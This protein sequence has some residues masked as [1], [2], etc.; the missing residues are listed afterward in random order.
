MPLFA[1][2]ATPSFDLACISPPG[3]NDS[4]ILVPGGGGASKTG[5][6]NLIQLAT[7]TKTGFKFKEHIPTDNGEESHLCST[8]CSS[9]VDEHVVVCAVATR[10]CLVYTL[11]ATDNQDSKEKGNEVSVGSQLQLSFLADP[12]ESG[13]VNCSALTSTGLLITAGDDG[14]CRLWQLN[15]PEE[16]ADETVVEKAPWSALLVK[17]L[18]GHSASV[19]SLSLHPL[20]PW[21]ASGSKDGTIKIWNIDSYT[22]VEDIACTDGVSG[23]GSTAAGTSA[24]S[25][26]TASSTSARSV[27]STDASAK[28][29]PGG[30]SSKLECRGC[31]FSNDGS[32]LLAIQSGKRGAT[33]LVR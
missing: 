4:I 23:T 33:Y 19:M 15:I 29:T 13:C 10:Q 9:I 18:A 5:V 6:K 24:T 2:L 12:K 1:K 27:A 21:V 7:I 3:L 11:F 8:I 25:T 22:L 20:Q 16:V 28:S 31:V 14:V 26:A 32:D 30:T 17:E